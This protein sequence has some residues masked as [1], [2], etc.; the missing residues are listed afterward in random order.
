[1]YLKTS[2]IPSINL[3]TLKE[4]DENEP[5]LFGKKDQEQ[6]RKAIVDHHEQIRFEYKKLKKQTSVSLRW[7]KDFERE[8]VLQ[9]MQELHLDLMKKL[10]RD[11]Q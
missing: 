6:K 2:Y 5:L 9:K 8:E 7:N 4:H 11:K 3:N 10:P 1:M